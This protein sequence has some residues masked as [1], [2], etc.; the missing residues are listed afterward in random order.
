M[1]IDGEPL[2]SHCAAKLSGNSDAQLHNTS[3][4][5]VELLVLQAR[6]IF[7]W[8][9]LCHLGRP[10]KEP[11]VQHGPFVMT[12]NDEIR[13]AFTDYQRTQFGRWPWSSDDP[14]HAREKPR[15]AKFMDGRLEERGSSC[16]ADGS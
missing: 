15:F 10:I 14:A 16:A 9:P 4:G 13:Q 8:H 12:S 3:S 2:K 11:V 6:T 7:P 5:D 1:S